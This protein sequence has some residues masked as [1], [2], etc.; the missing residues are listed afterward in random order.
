MLEPYSFRPA[1]DPVSVLVPTRNEAGN[2]PELLRRMAR[3]LDGID[4]EIVFIDD[5]EDDTPTTIQAVTATGG[6]GHCRVV[7]V[8]RRGE[9]RWGGL[10][11][12]VVDG[13]HVA[14]SPWACVM[15]ADLQ[16]PPEVIPA[17]MHKATSE[18]ADLVVA[19]RYC[20]Q[21]RAAGL[22]LVRTMISRSST[23][24]ARALFPRRLRGVSDPLSGFFLLRRDAIDLSRLQPRGFKILVE[25][26]VQGELRSTEVG[27][28]FAR[29]LAGESKG[30]LAEG[31]TYL[32]R[33][34]ELR[35]A[36]GRRNVHRARIGTLEA[37]LVSAEPGVQLP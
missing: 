28:S 35:L 20:D 14:R 27:F 10:A 15:D 7:L 19:S 21:G 23:I 26:L 34:C 11:G 30:S 13:L 29:R 18:G 9:Q 8:H 2:I 6:A 33:L 22:N 3:A 31:L 17:L 1:S 37:E 12:A 25:L 16:H 4:S 32:R 24:A 5:S 36:L